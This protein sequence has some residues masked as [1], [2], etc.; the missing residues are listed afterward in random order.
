[1]LCTLALAHTA[2]VLPNVIDG[3]GFTVTVKLV[4]PD[5]HPVAFFTVIVPVYVP[6]AVPA[7]TARL[8]GLDVNVPFV[9]G[10]K[11]FVGLEF[12]VISYVL[13]EFVVAL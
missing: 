10:K 11:L 12:H 13:G 5:A 1:M 2:V 3:N 9:I 8:I 4:A 6:T 7:G